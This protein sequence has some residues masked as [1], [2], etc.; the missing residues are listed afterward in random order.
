MKYFARLLS[1]ACLVGAST[2]CAETTRPNVLFIAIDDLKPVLGAYGDPYA[3]TP[4]LDKIASQGRIFDKAYCQYAVCAP[5][6]ASLLTGLRP[7]TAEVLDLKTDV[8]DVLPEVITLPQHFGDSGYQVAGIGKIYHGGQAKNQDNDISFGGNW[9]YTNGGK[10]RYYEPGKSEEE[11]S[12]LAKGKAFWNVRPSLTDR[13]KVDDHGLA[14]GKMTQQAV[15]LIK[16][17]SK[18]RENTDKPFFLAVGYQ[19][20]HLPFNAPEKYWEL[21]DDTDFGYA[22]YRG[23]RQ[24]PTGSLPWAPPGEGV[25]MRAYDDY[26][27]GGIKDPAFAQHLAHAYYACVSYV[28]A[29]VGEL[30]TEL[31]ASGQADNT[32]IIVWGDHGWHLGDHDG[33]WAKHSNFEQ[34]TR[35]PL[36]ISYPGMPNPGAMNENVVEF[37]DIYPTLCDLA[38]IPLPEQPAE[39]ALQGSSMA[40]IIDNPDAPWSNLAFSQFSPM[41]NVMGHSL[42]NERYRL[43][44]WYE[45]G[46]NLDEKT[47]NDQ[48]VLTELYDYQ[49]DPGETKNQYSNPAYQAI[50]EAMFAQLDAGFGWKHAP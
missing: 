31:E 19:R 28:D 1:I 9:R 25:E 8:R 12:Q 7:D 48:V 35:A 4:N 14:D 24:V 47:Q 17:L 29:L 22:D 34:A 46:N 44:V 18:T 33:F 10:K 6:R 11:D 3:H 40:G 5:S 45:R 16:E 15:G 23:T 21:Y 43:T 42:R 41:R 49:S 39:L 20:P 32:I 13:G 50:A 30:L 38:G 2:A 27:K 36:L 26:P 37:V